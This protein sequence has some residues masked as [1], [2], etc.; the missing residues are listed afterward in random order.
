MLFQHFSLQLLAAATVKFARLHTDNFQESVE[1]VYS[2]VEMATPGSLL[3]KAKIV[4]RLCA[5]VIV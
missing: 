5:G 1:R 4:R 2:D 3:C